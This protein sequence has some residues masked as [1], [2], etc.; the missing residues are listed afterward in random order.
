MKLC[1]LN[2]ECLKRPGFFIFFDHP[3]TF[4]S[5]PVTLEN[6]DNYP[7][8]TI[9]KDSSEMQEKAFISQKDLKEH[10]TAKGGN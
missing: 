4:F 10:L 1:M 3:W 6:R 7:S 2:G 8:P 5:G 9:N